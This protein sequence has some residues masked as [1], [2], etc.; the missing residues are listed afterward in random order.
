MLKKQAAELSKLS[1]ENH[2]KNE[3]LE[4]YG[5][6]LCLRVDGISAENN[7]SSDDVMNLTKSAFKEAK[8]SVRKMFWIVPIESGLF[9]L[10]ELAEKSVKVLPYYRKLTNHVIES[11]EN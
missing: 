9:I 6:R 8:V 11:S 7:K 3:E 1:T 4:Q 10:T 5:R 2:S